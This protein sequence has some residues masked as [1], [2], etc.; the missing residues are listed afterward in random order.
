MAD[1]PAALSASINNF[2]LRCGLSPQA[3]LDCHAFLEL[4]FPGKPI[5]P[6]QTQGYCSYTLHVDDRI[7]QFRPA[8]YKLDLDIINAAKDVYGSYAPSTVSFGTLHPSGLLVYII[9]KIPGIS[10]QDFKAH[11]NEHPRNSQ[12]RETL[13]EDFALFLSKSWHKHSNLSLPTGKIGSTVRS[14]LEVLSKEL[15][16]RFQHI[17]K[18]ILSQLYL[19]ETLP[20]VLVHGDIVPSN[21]LLDPSTGH[22]HGLVDWAE[23][24]YLPFGICLYG[25]E[26]ILGYMTPKGFVYYT[27]AEQCRA[28]FWARLKAEI[29]ELADEETLKAV[30]LA[31]DLGVLLWHGFAFDDGA[32]DRVVQERRD[33]EEIF[34]LEALLPS[35]VLEG[36]A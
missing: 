8:K 19:T 6:A 33:C 13:S 26:E 5:R 27:N 36:E 21:I 32:I 10:Y 20:V 17:A 15:P 23:A 22:L 11:E 9:D 7:G 34:Y 25:L 24:E 35:R 4:H 18:H 28:A 1:E 3:R 31:R 16:P 30:Y 29:P 2:F 12:V 14:R